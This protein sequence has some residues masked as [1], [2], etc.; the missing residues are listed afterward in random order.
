LLECC[1]AGLPVWIIRGPVHEYT[2]PPHTL[3][4]LR[5]RDQRPSRRGAN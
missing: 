5:P 4:L 1:E 2:D 3:G